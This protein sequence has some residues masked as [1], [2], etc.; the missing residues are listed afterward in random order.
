MYI[1]KNK[2]EIKFSGTNLSSYIAVVIVIVAVP[3]L[4]QPK[5]TFSSYPLVI[6]NGFTFIIYMTNTLKPWEKLF[7]LRKEGMLCHLVTFIVT[8]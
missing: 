4:S 2:A 7:T 1:D 5:L 8:K 3:S 6:R